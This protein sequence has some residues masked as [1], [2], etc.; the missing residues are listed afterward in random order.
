MQPCVHCQGEGRLH[1]ERLLAVLLI[2]L[3]LIT[4]QTPKAYT[5]LTGVSQIWGCPQRW[6]VAGNINREWQLPASLKNRWDYQ[7]L[8]RTTTEHMKR[9]GKRESQT[10]RTCDNFSL[11]HHYFILHPPGVQERSART[12]NGSRSVRSTEPSTVLYLQSL[13]L[14]SMVE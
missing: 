7:P 11:R 3:R 1:E 6:A 4:L 5:Q 8:M 2:I 14:W 10:E 12:F 9:E 13:S